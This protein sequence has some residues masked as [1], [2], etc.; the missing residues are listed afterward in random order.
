MHPVA[1]QPRREIVDRHLGR[2]MIEGVEEVHGRPRLWIM[3]GVRKRGRDGGVGG[4]RGTG[5]SAEKARGRN[6]LAQ[7]FGES[8]DRR[9]SAPN[10]YAATA[11]WDISITRFGTR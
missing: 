10:T 11:M 7:A 1:Q 3:M 5:T 9:L 8:G 4:H 2:S 6:Y